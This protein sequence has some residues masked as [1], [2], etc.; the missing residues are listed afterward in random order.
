MIRGI[1]CVP[2][3][4]ATRLRRPMKDGYFT[5]PDD[6]AATPNMLCSRCQACGEYYFPRRVICA[7]ASC[8][9]DGLEE[10]TVAARGTLY[11]YTWIT[12]PLFGSTRM[13]H[14]DGYG[15]G[16]VDLPEGPRVQAPLAGK[17]ADYTVGM[18]LVGEL[19]PL[20]DEGGADVVLLRFR[21]VEA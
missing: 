19:E 5:V 15:V 18:K 4:T 14:M 17:Q 21:P 1:G 11:S 8:L 10:V 3:T 13:E 20:R 16:Q 7:K 6:P 2:M 12:L 9:H